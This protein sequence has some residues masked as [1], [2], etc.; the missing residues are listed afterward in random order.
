MKPYIKNSLVSNGRMPGIEGQYESKL[1][2]DIL[3]LGSAKSLAEY[4]GDY[5]KGTPALTVNSFGKGKAY[6][7]A[8]LPSPDFLRKF[9][10]Q[11]CAEQGVQPVLE[12]PD[13]VEAVV[14]AKGDKEYLFVLNHNYSPAQVS[15]PKGDYL[16]L[17]TN[18]KAASVLD[19]DA[20]QVA[21]LRK[22]NH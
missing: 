17:L 14:R 3:Q 5:F 8:T 21:I 9:L 7:V 1:W 18:K 6:Y 12:T 19:L 10:R 22:E 2:C 4:G 20:V 15:L 11:V 13:R 16:N